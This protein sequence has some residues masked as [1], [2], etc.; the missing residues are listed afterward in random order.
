MSVRTLDD[1]VREYYSRQELRSEALA[2]LMSLTDLSRDRAGGL[3]DAPPRSK[4]LRVAVGLAAALL[5]AAAGLVYLARDEQPNSGNGTADRAAWV[6]SEVAWNHLKNEA[7]EF[8]GNDYVALSRQMGR[9]EFELRPPAR[10]SHSPYEVLGARYCSIQG[11]RAAQIKLRDR[12]ARVLTLYETP[13]NEALV[14][15]AFPAAGREYRFDGA[16][17]TLWR[18]N[19]VF[20]GL[21]QTDPTGPPE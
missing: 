7:I 15:A 5:L 16:R 14:P 2:R 3:A 18:E 13:W 8:P 20:L 10:L 21:A 4:R 12:K 1:C 11:Q 9:L 6:A 19:D 17:V